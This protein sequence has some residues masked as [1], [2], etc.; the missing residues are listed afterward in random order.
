M[1]S[2]VA[3]GAL[4][5]LWQPRQLE[6][7]HYRR[8]GLARVPR[9]TWPEHLPIFC[10]SPP[11]TFPWLQSTALDKAPRLLGLK[12]LCLPV[13]AVMHTGIAALKTY[14]DDSP[15]SYQLRVFS[16]DSPGVYFLMLICA[17]RDFKVLGRHPP[18]G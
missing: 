10:S 5:S 17:F 12:S 4:R 7:A 6:E 16:A 1:I 18:P 9:E 14:E 3:M 8:R 15:R 13:H 11:E 2:R